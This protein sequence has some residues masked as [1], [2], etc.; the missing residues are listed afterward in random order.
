M[1]QQ[2]KEKTTKQ[3]RTILEFKKLTPFFEQC[4]AGDQ[5]FDIRKWDGQDS[6]FNMI[7]FA[8]PG[9][10]AIKFVHPYTGESFIRELTGWRYITDTDGCKVKPIWIM[11]FLGE[12]VTE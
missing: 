7:Y 10:L 4:Q 11:L 1:A 6:R 3:G 2:T 9:K 5:P 8:T 12:L